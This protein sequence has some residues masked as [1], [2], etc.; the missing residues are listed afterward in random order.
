M[1]NEKVEVITEKKTMFS[2]LLTKSQFLP[3]LT[4]TLKRFYVILFIW[5]KAQ[6][7]KAFVKI[8]KQKK[9][10]LPQLNT[11]PI[12]I[13]HD[14]IAGILNWPEL[15]DTSRQAN[16]FN[17]FCRL[18]TLF[19][20]TQQESDSSSQCWTILA[21]KNFDQLL[22]HGYTNF[23]RTI[24]HNY[25][26]FLVQQNDP[27]ITAV[28][29]LLPISI[30]EA[31]RY[32]AQQTH[33][34][35]FNPKEQFS[36][37]Y[38]VFLLWEYVKKIDVKNYL[39]KL[40]EPLEGNPLLVHANG[41]SMSQDLANSLIEYYSINELVPLSEASH[42]LEIGGG[43]GRNAHVILTLN[44]HIKF[45]VVDILPALYIAQRYLTSI[46][47]DRTIFK[48]RDFSSYN[49]VKKEIKEASIIFLLPHQLT[50]LPPQ[51]FNLVMNISSFG[52]MKLEQIDWYFK[53]INRLTSGYFYTKQWNTSPNPFDNL[54]LR[55]T[56][57]PYPEH[58]KTSYSRQCLVQTEFFEALFK[59]N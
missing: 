41:K 11:Q 51:H 14:E 5:R 59:V 58:W 23:K 47:Q 55:K 15:L 18:F 24:G 33:D 16:G 44:P 19:T 8:G 1:E 57:Y 27:Q 48:A 26:N 40:E 38:F 53:Q 21:S 29:A 34:P 54:I 17:E 22:D 31:C 20:D 28:E 39:D 52:E 4:K 9:Y 30:Q 2:R 43:Y 10:F 49:E 3:S 37:W 32:A 45:Y 56:D 13:P 6:R 46:F 42:I 7:L 36:Y 25:F 50:L 12:C 35:A